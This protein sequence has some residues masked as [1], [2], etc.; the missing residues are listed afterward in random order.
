MILGMAVVGERRVWSVVVVGSQ[1]E[2]GGRLPGREVND[3][4]A[5]YLENQTSRGGLG[6][7]CFC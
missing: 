3:H 1:R 4:I 5:I 2:G 7:G 6:R